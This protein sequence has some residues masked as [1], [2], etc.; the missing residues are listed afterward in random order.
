MTTIKA[1]N[2]EWVN[3]SNHLPTVTKVEGKAFAIAVAKNIEVL[4]NS[5]QHL[6]GVL[7]PTPEFAE[8]S[9]KVKAYQDKKDKKSI[10]AIKKIETENADIIAQRQDQISKVNE[11]LTQEL[12][13]EVEAI[14]TDMYPET[15][16]AEQIMG[17]KILNL[18]R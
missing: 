8:L 5:L 11:L 13:L 10:A 17:L 3:L 7:S 1:K 12:E 16:N 18:N 6:E 2:G 15:I 9:E 14:T 4:K